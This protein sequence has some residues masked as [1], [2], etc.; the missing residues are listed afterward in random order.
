[1][2]IDPMQILNA[3]PQ[4]IYLKD[5][6]GRYVWVN[7]AFAKTAG[8][9][10]KDIVGKTDAELIWKDQAEEIRNDEQLVISENKTI[11]VERFQSRAEGAFKIILSVTPYI[12]HQ[13]EIRG[14]VGNFFDC[15]DHFVTKTKGVFDNNKLYIEFTNKWLS[16]TELRVLFFLFHGFS[17]EKIAEKTFTSVSNIRFHL[18]NIKNKMDCSKSE[19]Q[20]VAI[21]HG[22]FWKVFSLQHEIDE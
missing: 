7:Q 20:E 12:D 17:V 9:N 4:S 1:M 15:T 11:C 22:I 8:Q 10:V 16:S 21:K 6:E 13:G 18:E 14:T 2:N 19:I 3:V 5:I